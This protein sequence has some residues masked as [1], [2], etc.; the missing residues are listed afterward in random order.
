MAI[1]SVEKHPSHKQIE[2]D[3]RQ[4]VPVATVSRAYDLSRSAVTRFRNRV[5]TPKQQAAQAEPDAG[6]II[7]QLR[8]LYSAATAAVIKAR[9]GGN[10]A[11]QIAAQRE[12]RTTLALV[13]RLMEKYDAAKAASGAPKDGTAPPPEAIQSALIRALE[14]HPKAKAAVVSALTRL[15]AEWRPADK[16]DG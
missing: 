9:D 8:S 3:I 5:L 12:A 10:A 11:S 13:A 2:A 14:P 7:K 6:E 16:A 4:G 15:E 1:S